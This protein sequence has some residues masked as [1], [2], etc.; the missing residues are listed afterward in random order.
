[1]GLA[2]INCSQL[3]TLAGPARPRIGS[4]M[5]GIDVWP[6]A[7]MLIKR[8]YITKL[9]ISEVIEAEANQLGYEIVDAY[10][11]VITPGWVDAH[12]H[13]VFGG[14][15]AHEFEMRSQG[16]TYQEIAAAG[17]GIKST[18]AAT[19]KGRA[20]RIRQEIRPVVLE[21]RHYHDRGEVRLRS[22]RGR[23]AEDAPGHP[24]AGQRDPHRLRP[25]FPRGTLRPR[26]CI[27]E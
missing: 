26:R 1:M 11:K 22:Y 27:Q 16:A 5:H 8:G 15:R 13:P 4:E 24:K 3:V 23:R 18:V 19:R 9:E 10:G 25:D 20:G 21:Q 2:V 7:G 6:N 12:A 17:G 14:N